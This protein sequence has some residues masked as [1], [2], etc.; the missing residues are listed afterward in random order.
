MNA[1]TSDVQLAKKTDSSGKSRAMARNTSLRSEGR[2]CASGDDNG[3]RELPE[4]EYES[5]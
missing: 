2:R 5:A 1:R 4:V 3:K